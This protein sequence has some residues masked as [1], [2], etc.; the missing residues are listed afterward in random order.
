MNHYFVV[1]AAIREMTESESGSSSWAGRIAQSC[2]LFG[3]RLWLVALS[4]E[5]W[6]G[7]PRG[8]CFAETANF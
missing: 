7:A 2:L 1:A 6:L 8:V 4:K 3:H 5:D